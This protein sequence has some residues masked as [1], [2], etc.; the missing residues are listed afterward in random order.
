MARKRFKGVIDILVMLRILALF[1]ILLSPTVYSDDISLEENLLS[2][3]DKYRAKYYDE[4]VMLDEL[5]QSYSSDIYEEHLIKTSNGNRFTSMYI[6]WILNAPI[7]IEKIENIFQ[8]NCF[9]LEPFEQCLLIEG[10][11]TSN[12]KNPTITVTLGFLEENNEWKIGGV[13]LKRKSGSEFKYVSPLQS[14]Q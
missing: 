11:D 13:L 9:D 5:F 8:S 7:E 1:I 12:K 10:A 14:N 6:G 4:S 2:I 3:V